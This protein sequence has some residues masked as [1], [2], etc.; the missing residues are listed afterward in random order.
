MSELIHPAGCTCSLP[1]S[2]SCLP[3]CETVHQQKSCTCT[4]VN[5]HVNI[6]VVASQA[7]KAAM[8]ENVWLIPLTKQPACPSLSA[9]H[10]LC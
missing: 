5:I 8:L 10:T 7:S 2:G 3:L 1:S 4:E 9:A 6:Y